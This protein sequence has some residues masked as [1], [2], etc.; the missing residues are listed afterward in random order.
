[1][2]QELNQSG[3]YGK[4]ESSGL[5]MKPPYQLTDAD[6]LGNTKTIQ[7]LLKSDYKEILEDVFDYETVEQIMIAEVNFMIEN[8]GR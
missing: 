7:N 2:T 4:L 3:M 8:H 6:R 5:N 1:M